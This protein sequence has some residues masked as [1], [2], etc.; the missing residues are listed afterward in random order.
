MHEP[1][2]YSI[3]VRNNDNKEIESVSWDYWHT[4]HI[5]DDVLSTQKIWAE[6]DDKQVYIHIH[7]AQEINGAGWNHGKGGQGETIGVE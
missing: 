7:S 6:V 1:R 2:S 4:I 3:L 5:V